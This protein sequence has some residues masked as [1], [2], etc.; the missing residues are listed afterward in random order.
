MLLNSDLAACCS[1]ANQ[2]QV[3]VGKEGLLYPRGQQ[4]GEKVDSC[5]TARSPLPIRGK[6]L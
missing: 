4:R 1:K 3:L 2:R 5:A 6:R